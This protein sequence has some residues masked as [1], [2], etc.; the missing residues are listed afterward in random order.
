MVA[1]IPA[2]LAPRAHIQDF[3]NASGTVH[4]WGYADRILPCTN[5]VGSCEYLD[6]VYSAHEVGMLY[7]GIMWSVILGILLIWA[8]LRKVFPSTPAPSK[9]SS[10]CEAQAAASKSTLERLRNSTA[11]FSRRWFLPES[12]RW[13]FGHTT[14]LQ[15]A[16]LAIVVVYLTAFSFAGMYYASWIT[17]VKNSPGVYNLRSS[18]GPWS[19]R[20]GVLA[21]ALTP[22]SIMLSSRES[23]MSILTGV[24]Y[25]SFIFMHRW[26][27]YII[28]A[29]SALHTIGWCLIEI[30]FYQPQPK[31]GIE[32]IIQTYMIWG[33]VA[34]ILLTLLVLLSTKWAIRAFGYEFFRKAHYILAM[35]YIGACIGHWEQLQCFLIPALLIWVVDRFARLVRTALL[36]YNYLDDGSIGFKSAEALVQVFEDAENGDVVRLDFHHPQQAWEIGQHFFLCFPELSMWQSHPMTPLAPPTLPGAAGGK[37]GSIHSYV[38][39]AKAGQTKQLA[40]LAAKKL[41]ASTSG[42]AV[43][44]KTTSGGSS[45][46]SVAPPAPT[47]SVILTGA[48]G[49]A[50]M[51]S[52]QQDANVLCVAGGT[53]VTFVLPVLLDIVRNAPVRGR[54]I[55]LVWAVRHARD[56]DWVAPE[57]AELR[58]AGETHNVHVDVFLTRDQKKSRTGGGAA[59]RVEESKLASEDVAPASAS[60]SA[61]AT[62]SEEI[63]EVANVAVHRP[64]KV[65]DPEVRRPSMNT[66]VG[67]FV[68]GVATGSTTVYASGPLGMLTDLRSAVASQ[69]SG[70]K[71]WRGEERFN[72]RLVSDDRVEW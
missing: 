8:F 53:G 36:H 26:L 39:R 58:A 38:I 15:V 66:V 48:Y 69:N 31:V 67:Q 4:Y 6:L 49:Q 1:Q 72:V 60:S 52:L 55:E 70:G 54:K 28:F 46:G 29:Q 51:K 3:T 17:P 37:T 14:R 71:V 42:S 13:V 18:L 47:V 10:S 9:P 16:I 65:E 33:L 21:Y 41:A 50:T 32:W 57:L 30:R 7:T 63:H 5:D 12:I 23:I 34:M 40:L 2:T 22:L 68:G 59:A 24:P 44:E 19:D 11:S 43:V 20:I 62:S 25:Q 56:M 35:V 64:A 45:S 27:G 61:S